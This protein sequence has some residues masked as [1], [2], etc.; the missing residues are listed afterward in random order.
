MTTQVRDE[1]WDG[2]G[3]DEQEIASV[4][5]TECDQW[6]AW[7]CAAVTRDQVSRCHECDGTQHRVTPEPQFSCLES[8]Q[9]R[10]S[11]QRCWPQHRRCHKLQV[12]G[13]INEEVRLYSRCGAGRGSL[14]V[15]FTVPSLSSSG[16]PELMLVVTQKLCSATGYTLV[17]LTLYSGRSC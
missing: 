15:L 16:W 17:I 12:Y 14:L 3:Y 11:A 13:S 2:R 4:S 5:V 7:Q 10:H 9:S 6:A 8:A 1:W